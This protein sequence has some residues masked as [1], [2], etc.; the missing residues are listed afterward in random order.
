M[1]LQYPKLGGFTLNVIFTCGGTGGHIN[2]AIAVA[3]VLRERYPDCR[4]LFV[5]GEGGM[6]CDLVRK[7]GYNLE[8]LDPRS[9]MRGLTPA[10]L[11]H[12]VRGAV[13]TAMALIKAR[14]LIRRFQP[15]VVLGTGGYASFP[16]LRAA[17]AM[18]IPTCVHESN[19]VPGLTTRMVADKA[20]RILVSFAE[21]K[22]NYKHP[23]R[24][25]VVGM[26][27]RQEFIYTKKEDARKKLG[28]DQRPVVVSVWGSLGAREMNKVTAELFRLELEE[29]LPWQ[30]I[31]ATGSYGWQ[32]MPQYVQDRGVDLA[33][34]PGITMKK[35]IYD[36]PTVM[37]AAD[38][39]ICRAGAS[40]LN[41]IAASGTPCIVV[42]SP[43]V[44]DNHQEKNARIL[45]DRG[46]AQVLLEKDCTPQRLFAEIQSLLGNPARCRAM[47]RALLDM[48]V[49]DSA[50]KICDT[51]L[52]LGGRKRPG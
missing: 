29:G 52:E 46:A 45:Q 33:R 19:A 10:A 16:I 5:G 9:F 7:A 8:T 48:A 49:V 36:M 6:E 43:N 51:V 28:L 13:L 42:P 14:R 26:P 4:I 38:V 30:H 17:T 40:T 3:N 25:E 27:V 1:E 41:E 34:C 11:W 39:V 31:H 21:S 50:Q 2:P 44:A 20:S 12:N 23:E 35:Y 22:A 24:V 37:A 47:R 32:W 18:G 15:D